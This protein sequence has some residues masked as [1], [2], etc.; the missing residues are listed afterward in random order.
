MTEL[1]KAKKLILPCLAAL[2]GAVL[3]GSTATSSAQVTGSGARVGMVNA[4][5]AAAAPPG[6][7]VLQSPDI[8]GVPAL[9]GPVA[10]PAQPSSNIG[11]LEVSPDQ[12]V[13]GTPM[14][15]SGSGLPANASVELT[16]STADATWMVQ[17]EADTVNYRGSTDNYFSVVLDTT[18]TNAGGAFKVALKAPVDFGGL[19]DIY[20]VIK[21]TE[22]AHG[23]F[24][25]MR[26]ITVTPSSGPVGT[27]ITITYSGLGAS[28]YTGGASLLYDNHYVGEMM[29]NW[30]RGTARAV[31]R[32]SGGVGPHTIQ[33]GNAISYLYLNVPQ[34]PIP[35]TNGF[36]VT[37]SVTKDDGPPPAS[38]A[39]PVSVAP[40]ISARTTLQATGLATNSKVIASLATTDGPVNTS[41]ALSASGFTS[42]APISMVWS[43][44][45]GNRVNCKSTCWAFASTPLGTAKPAGGALQ[46]N[47]SVPDGLGGWHVVQLMQNGQQLAQIPFYVEESIVGQGVSSVVLKEGQPFTIHIKGVGWTQLDNTVG[48]DYDNSYMGYGCGFNSNGDVLLHL[49]A[50]GGPGTHLIDLY[51]MLYSLSPSF[52]DTPYGMVPVLT[53]A[54][55]YPGLA[56]GYHLPSLHF[57]ITIV[58]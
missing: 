20:A 17:T 21:G 13:A 19:H 18:T 28:L 25:L 33:I 58:K 49:I 8:P 53:Y 3:L 27:P 56:L 10:S 7:D 15:I 47:I 40:T 30:T 55:D 1:L 52:A 48:V 16:W 34:S 2:A 5:S 51:P 23:G 41:V 12:G 42:N 9:P 45:V 31:I 50:T 11:I 26:T 57:A 37:F 39:W 54:Q 36:H 35:Y 24:L 32:A 38:I 44:V 4:A 6:V 43:T 22:D 14:T 46:T 29:A